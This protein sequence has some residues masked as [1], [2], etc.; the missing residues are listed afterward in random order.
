MDWIDLD[1]LRDVVNAVMKL[2][3]PGNSRLAEDLLASQEGLCSMELV[4]VLNAFFNET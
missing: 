4:S 2:R 3:V 1:Q